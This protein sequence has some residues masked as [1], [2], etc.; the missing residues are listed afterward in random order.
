M[1]IPN[2]HSRPSVVILLTVLEGSKARCLVLKR[3]R[4]R[5]LLDILDMVHWTLDMVHRM[6]ERSLR[7]STSLLHVMTYSDAFRM[8]Y[9]DNDIVTRGI[10]NDV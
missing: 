10:Q 8:T 1:V 2:D 6:S 3:G 4:M 5:V 9:V 7:T